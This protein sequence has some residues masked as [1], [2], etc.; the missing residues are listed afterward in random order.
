MAIDTDPADAKLGAGAFMTTPGTHLGLFE[1]HV[2]D[3]QCKVSYDPPPDGTGDGTITLSSVTD[4][5]V[6]TFDV[7]L[8]NSEHLSGTFTPTACPE[9]ANVVGPPT[10]VP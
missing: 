4:T 9:L 10:C 8:E 5:V 7:V 6:G 3:A 2:T 1:S